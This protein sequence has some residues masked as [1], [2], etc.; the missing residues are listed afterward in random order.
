MQT[1]RAFLS[2]QLGFPSGWFGRLLLRLLNRNNAAMNDLVLHELQLSSGDICG[3]LSQS[4]LEIGFGG[5]DL[6]HKIADTGIPILTVGVER[7]PDALKICQ[8]RFQTLISQGKIAFHLGD[9]TKLP[10]PDRQ[11]SRVCTVNTLYF[12]SDVSQVLTECYRVLIPGGKLVI[13]YTSKTYLD[14]QQFSQ[15]GFTAYEVAEVERV[16]REA[17]FANI[18]TV[19]G[20]SDRHQ[21]FFCTSG[22]VTP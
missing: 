22:I 15:H 18:K 16:L 20:R 5:G 13:S 3:G 4:V 9:A 17:G 21:D 2:H 7:S 6:I 8:Q 10:F 1:F 11:F 14:Q 12:W 19:S